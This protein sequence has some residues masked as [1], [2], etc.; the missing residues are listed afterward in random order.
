MERG[1][2]NPALPGCVVRPTV[3]V[4][5]QSTVIEQKTADIM[6]HPV[7]GDYQSPVIMIYIYS[8]S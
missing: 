6:S 4:G 8:Q 5:F 1:V 7:A 3:Y 2:N